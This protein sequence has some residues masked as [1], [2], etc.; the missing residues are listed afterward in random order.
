MRYYD[1]T[2]NV[3]NERTFARI[4]VTILARIRLP[5]GISGEKLFKRRFGINTCSSC[6]E[7]LP[8][9]P[10]LTKKRVETLYPVNNDSGKKQ[11]VEKVKPKETKEKP[12]AKEKPDRRL[13]ELESLHKSN[14]VTTSL[15]IPEGKRIKLADSK[16]LSKPPTQFAGKQKRKANFEMEFTQ[17]LAADD[18]D[19]RMAD[20]D[21]LSEDDFPDTGDG[22]MQHAMKQQEKKNDSSDS[23]YNDSEMDDLIR[24]M[25]TP[26]PI[27]VLPSSP[28]PD[29]ASPAVFSK[30]RTR[31]V[32]SDD[33]APEMRSGPQPGASSA[34]AKRRK[35]RT[36]TRSPILSWLTIADRDFQGPRQ[37][38]FV[39][40]L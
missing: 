33:E 28:E 32:D 1:F 2:F 5:V 37:T 24:N 35:V 20:I 4:G 16:S 22:L 30:K 11:M 26:P 7:G 40:A 17:D 29:P 39:P 3:T 31:M 14:N 15:Q 38:P 13:Q 6:H 36:V 27:E 8:K 9:P 23:L 10:P 21:E 19:L 34:P 18:T 25:P 12:V